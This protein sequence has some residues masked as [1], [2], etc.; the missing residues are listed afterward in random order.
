MKKYL[1]LII[2]ILF[3]IVSFVLLALLW[4]VPIDGESFETFEVKMSRTGCH[5]FCPDYTVTLN[6]HGEVTYTGNAFVKVYDEQIYT[7]SQENVDIIREALI[8]SDFFELEDEYYE[9]VTDLPS[10]YITVSTNSKTKTIHDYEGTPQKLIDLET[11]FDEQTGILA[12]I[13]CNDSEFGYCTE[14]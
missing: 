14:P 3:L 5:G 10:T 12:F 13:K 8:Q 11:I 9:P 4:Q 7:I 6:S 2:A 1:P